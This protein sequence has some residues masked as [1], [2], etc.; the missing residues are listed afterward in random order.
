MKDKDFILILLFLLLIYGILLPIYQENNIQNFY[1]TQKITWNDGKSPYIFHVL[2]KMFY[3]QTI[4]FD[5]VIPSDDV[6]QLSRGHILLESDFVLLLYLPFYAIGQLFGNLISYKLIIFS[7]LIYLILTCILLYLL[8]REIGLKDKYA[9]FS[10]LFFGVCTGFFTYSH[11]LFS[12]ITSMFLL[13]LCF[14]LF[15]IRKKYPYWYIVPLFVLIF[16]EKMYILFVIPLFFLM[17]KKERKE[18]LIKI[19][20]AVI[21]ALLIYDASSYVLGRS[22]SIWST[23][24]FMD[25]TDSYG[26]YSLDRV[27]IEK[28]QRES[29]FFYVT[30]GSPG[31][32]FNS[33]GI[34]GS[35][36][37]ERGFVYNSPF[38]VF[39]ILGVIL[40][41]NKS[42]DKRNFWFLLAVFI[43]GMLP[44]LSPGGWAGGFTPRYVRFYFPAIF[45]LCFFSVFFV[46][47]NKN[48]FFRIIFIF[49]V[50]ISFLN[51]MSMAVRPDWNCELP[52]ECV[53][54][55]LTLWP[56]SSVFPYTPSRY[57]FVLNGTGLCN[58][59]FI[60]NFFVTDPC[61][62]NES[63]WVD[64][65]L[66]SPSNFDKLCI[67]F[68]G[69]YGG[70]D[71]TQGEVYLD[72]NFL[73]E[74]RVKPYSCNSTC[75]NSN[76]S[77]GSHLLRFKSSIYGACDSE[78][79]IWK[80]F[81]FSN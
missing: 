65:S 68:C 47:E 11:Y 70:G 17:E 60:G 76:I 36:F 16:G 53:S 12:G 35:M 71:M 22:E 69:G 75:L 79:I 6:I 34:F 37:S 81:W 56:F 48:K 40:F 13:S 58:A 28:D 57:P 27:L 77:M 19:F 74:V 31:L 50:G 26:S 32:Y 7:N 52:Y 29:S 39:S 45:S 30:G 61:W 9:F 15:S 3:N 44:S 46:Q 42:K 49:L 54:F 23:S 62:C 78:K 38:L 24:F 72:G 51:N 18:N 1:S 64:I 63:S 67:F 10:S 80:N 8:Q 73:G 4:F 20:L 21:L 59:S 41:F 14:Y 43:V 25:R 5:D 33:Y 55:D 2:S 66:D